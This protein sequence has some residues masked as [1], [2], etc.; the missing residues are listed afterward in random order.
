[1]E[2][3]MRRGFQHVKVLSWKYRL[4]TKKKSAGK[5]SAFFLQAEQIARTTHSR[6]LCQVER[7]EP[8]HMASLMRMWKLSTN[9]LTEDSNE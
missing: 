2:K 3:L 1:M 4:G 9:C 6:W 7:A 8:A 5:N